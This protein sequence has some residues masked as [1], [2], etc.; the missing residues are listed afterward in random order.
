MDI[1]KKIPSFLTRMD[2]NIDNKILVYYGEYRIDQIYNINDFLSNREI[3]FFKLQ[4]TFMSGKKRVMKDRYI[5]LTDIY[6]LLLDPVPDNK[7]LGKLLFWGDIRQLTSS[8]GSQEFTNHLILE[9]KNQEKSLVSFELVFD[10]LTISDFLELS[11]RKI[12]KLKDFYNIFHD[13]LNRHQDEKKPQDYEKLVLLIKF[14]EDI[15]NKQHS[16][17]TVKELMALYQSIIEVMSERNDDGY[18]EYLSKLKVLLQNQEYQKLLTE[19]DD[20]KSNSTF[21][22]SNS[23]YNVPHE[24]DEFIS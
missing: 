4:Q 17:N 18:I 22:L 8:R 20:V 13:E 21:E 12:N 3:D 9:W 14:K 15:L 16:I 19:K 11:S 24:D 6:F 1:V 2:E 7:N 10:S 23:Y 5:V